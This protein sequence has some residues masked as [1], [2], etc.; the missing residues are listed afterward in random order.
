MHICNCVLV[1]FHLSLFCL[2]SSIASTPSTNGA[3]ET[4]SHTQATT[5]MDTPGQS[6]NRD[7]VLGG[8]L[9]AHF[10]HCFIMYVHIYSP[11]VPF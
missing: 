1:L 11:C 2:L 10:R 4:P 6:K 5:S 7:Q 8:L 3:S 9:C